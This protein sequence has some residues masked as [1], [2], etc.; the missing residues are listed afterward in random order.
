MPINSRQMLAP[1]ALDMEQLAELL[2]AEQPELDLLLQHIAAVKRECSVNTCEETIARYEQIFNQPPGGKTLEER[3]AAILFLLN[4]RLLVT[5]KYMEEL[6]S[7][8]LQCRTWIE[9]HFAQYA[10]TV[11]IDGEGK[12]SPDFTA[13]RHYVQIL[14]PAHLQA[15]LRYRQTI[16]GK[17][18]TRA[19]GSLGLFLRVLPY[20][21]ED[22]QGEAMIKTSAF[23][24]GGYTLHIRARGD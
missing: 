10:F 20:Q 7:G 19:F 18:G 16:G 1:L 6:L 3:R 4:A 11:N 14:K 15:K 22:L 8:V 12:N 21:A 23:T 24:K 9:E 2:A 17:I 5:P 13:A